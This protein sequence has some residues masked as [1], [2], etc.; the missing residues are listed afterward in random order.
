MGA[1]T[2]PRDT[3][4][5]HATAGPGGTRL[6]ERLRRLVVALYTLLRDAGIRWSDDACYRL[7]LSLAYA[8]LFSL[9]PLLLL[10]VTSVGFFLGNDGSV[11]QKL[12]AA[13]AG[14]ASP[15]SRTMLD[16]TL[17]DMQTHTTARGIGAMV[18]L[19]TLVIGASGVFAEMQSTLNLIW[20]V[21]PSA[22]KGLWSTVLEAVKAKAFSFAVVIVAACALLGSLVASTALAA[23][24]TAAQRVAGGTATWSVLEFG[25]SLGLLALL[26]ATIYRLV[27]QTHVRWHDVWAGALLSAF[28]FTALKSLLA[29]YLAHLASYAAY[30][31]V[32]AVLGLLTWIYI[33]SLVFF[34]GAEFT[35]IFAER[36]GSLSKPSDAARTEAPA[37]SATRGASTTTRS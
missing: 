30:G 9:F 37:G 17:R 27:P 16:E 35:R 25:F 20:R 11:R 33:A 34:Y 14:T 7:G 2:T 15:A 5:P 6:P 8:A 4:G 32:G 31:A 19:V 18:G 12:L 28:L 10:A 22:S 26:L 13:I 36:F 21:P 3:P 23:V 24:G 29:W 1:S